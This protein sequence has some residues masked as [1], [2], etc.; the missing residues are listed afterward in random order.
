MFLI[1]QSAYITSIFAEYSQCNVGFKLVKS[2]EV[3]TYRLGGYANHL[4]HSGF[5]INSVI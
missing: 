2:A 4:H 1:Q 5:Y 3:E